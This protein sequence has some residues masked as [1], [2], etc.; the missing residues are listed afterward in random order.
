MVNRLRNDQIVRVSATEKKFGIKDMKIY[1]YMND[2]EINII[3]E[4]ISDE[5][6][7][8]FSL[9]CTVY[10]Q[11]GDMIESLENDTYGRYVVTNEIK[12][13]VFFNGYPFK[14][15]EYLDEGVKVSK[16]RIVPC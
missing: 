12:K 1:A 4:I 14:F 10:D 3:G 6:L 13:K 9:T 8:D 7:K 2:N 16:I 15:S 5:I 11:D